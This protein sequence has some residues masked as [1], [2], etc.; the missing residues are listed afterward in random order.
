MSLARRLLL[1]WRDFQYS[2]PCP[3]D[4][5]V[6]Q[7]R[8]RAQ[9]FSPC[10]RTSSMRLVA[11]LILLSMLAIHR[12]CI[13]A[14]RKNSSRG[15]GLPPAASERLTRLRAGS[16]SFLTVSN[17]RGR[18]LKHLNVEVKNA[19]QSKASGVEVWIEFSGGL[20]YPLRGAKSLQPGQ[21]ALYVLKGAAVPTTA[22][23]S[24]VIAQCANCRR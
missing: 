24:R 6:S 7:N 21:V 16:P 15:D 18:E 2:Q 17:R 19:G 5:K 1:R 11:L 8:F 4:E 10:N 13:A 23:S 3:G 14:P 20:A 22:S 12:P 9:L